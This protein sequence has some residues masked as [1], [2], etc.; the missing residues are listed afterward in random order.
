MVAAL[1]AKDAQSGPEPLHGDVLDDGHG[2][3]SSD[4]SWKSG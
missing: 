4:R 3:P 1:A 2:E